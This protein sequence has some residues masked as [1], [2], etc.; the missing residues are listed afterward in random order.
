MRHYF[1]MHSYEALDL[2]QGIP[3]MACAQGIRSALGSRSCG[4]ANPMDIV[5]NLVNR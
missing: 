5:F 2:S 3:F 4:T 1:D